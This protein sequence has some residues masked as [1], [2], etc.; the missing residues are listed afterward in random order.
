[1]DPRN[2]LLADEDL[3]EGFREIPEPPKPQI[4]LSPPKQLDTSKSA[5]AYLE[6]KRS[7]LLFFLIFTLTM[8]SS[9]Q[10]ILGTESGHQVERNGALGLY[11]G[12][13]GQWF[14]KVNCYL[15]PSLSVGG[16]RDEEN[17]SAQSSRSQVINKRAALLVFDLICFLRSPSVCSLAV[18]QH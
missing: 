17:A 3:D 7:L 14:Y 12:H 13:E 18:G 15:T 10:A 11:P 2:L 6:G 16:C 1:M 4:S 5:S 9:A 8:W